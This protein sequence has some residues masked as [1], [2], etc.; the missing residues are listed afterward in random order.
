LDAIDGED[1]E[2]KRSRRRQ[3]KASERQVATNLDESQKEVRWNIYS[4][5]KRFL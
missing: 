3:K 1:A 5:K 2:R 4:M